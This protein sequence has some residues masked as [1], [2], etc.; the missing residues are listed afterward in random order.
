MMIVGALSLFRISESIRKGNHSAMIACMIVSTLFL[1][2]IPPPVAE[3]ATT[4]PAIRWNAPASITYGVPLSSQQLCA[5]TSIAGS[6]QY[7]PASGT[8]LKAG[9]Q[10]ISVTFVPADKIHYATATAQVT[11]TVNPATPVIQWAT[12][13]AITY[14]TALSNL[15]LNASASIAGKFTYN[16]AAGKVLGAGQ[17]RLSVTF[18]PSNQNYS[19]ATKQVLLE[20]NRAQP[21]L[22][23]TPASS[24]AINIPLSETELNAQAYSTLNGAKLS[25]TYQYLP[26]AG[27]AFTSAGTSTLS[28]IFHP[29]D[30]VNFASTSVDQS[31][32]VTQTGIVTWGDSL[33]IG[34][35]GIVNAGQYPSILATLTNLPIFNLGVS[36]NTST[37]IAIRQGTLS[38]SATIAGNVIPASGSVA[39]SFPTGYDPRANYPGI[40]GSIAGIHGLVTYLSATNSYVF[41]RDTAGTAVTLSGAKPFVVDRPYA[42]L[43]SI[44]WAGRNDYLT[45]DT[46]LSNIAGMVKS[47]SAKQHYAVLSVI[48]TL[49]EPKGGTRYPILQKINLA[50]AKLYG[51]HY[52]DVRSALVAAYDPTQA[53]DLWYFQHDVPPMSMHAIIGVGTLDKTVSATNT[54]FT[55]TMSQGS[56]SVGGVVKIGTGGNSEGAAITAVSGNTATVARNWSGVNCSHLAGSKV[57]VYDPTHLNADADKII[58]NMVYEYLKALGDME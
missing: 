29:S 17:Q 54:S 26:A 58:A 1:G 23:W 44:F 43:I 25:G 7:S 19:T 47:T 57:I 35:Q 18:V 11:L 12:P 45:P 6:L 34:K 28:V 41:T 4:T 22:T 16:P 21:Q 27:K 42:S 48:N 51:T 46:V 52:L 36:G 56:L 50:L 55:V 49:S 39:V 15:Q 13:R 31:I 53:T 20:V 37:Q 33:T 3:A 30:S 40:K 9:T 5:T 38:T 14:G 10:K 8:I 24:I 32:E 2:A